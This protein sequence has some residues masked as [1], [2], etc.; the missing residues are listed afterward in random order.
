[1]PAGPVEFML[2]A[3]S[4]LVHQHTG[5]DLS[6]RYYMDPLYRLDRD[7]EAAAWVQQRFPGFHVYVE[8]GEFEAA[9]PPAIRV[10]GL[11]P[12]L[13]VSALF[14]AEIRFWDD[15]EPAVADEPLKDVADPLA[16]T[17]PPIRENP[18]VRRLVAQVMDMRQR[19]GD[20]MAINPPFFWDDSGWAFV[21]A[22]FTTAYK[23]R[24]E[25]FFTELYSHPAA[26]R[27]LIDVAART[28]VLLVDFFAGVGGRQVTGIHLGDC[29]ASLVSA[30]HYGQF[31]APALEKM[32]GRYGPARLHSC[33][34]STP[35]A[36]R[37]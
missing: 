29:A 26:A 11:Q 10:G 16:V 17:V 37:N 2:E 8:S 32:A 30:R 13:I 33:G 9:A 24:G 3:T 31:A 20:K 18:L 35:P 34:R 12:Y 23:L 27:H 21:H 7:R 5:L 22:P 19:Y 15:H 4:Y 36:A 25:R 14:G 1:M 28:T 6:E